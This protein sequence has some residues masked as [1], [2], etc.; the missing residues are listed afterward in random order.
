MARPGPVRPRALG[1]G[2]G[3]REAGRF[4]VKIRLQVV[5][6]FAMDSENRWNDCVSS[7]FNSHAC[8]QSYDSAAPTSGSREKAIYDSINDCGRDLK[9]CCATLK[10][11][12]HSSTTSAVMTARLQRRHLSGILRASVSS[13]VICAE[14][15]A[16]AS[17][18]VLGLS[19]CEAR[20]DAW[21]EVLSPRSEP[22][23]GRPPVLL[24][25][26]MPHP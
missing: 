20:H 17:F 12:C 22:G 8:L 1:S 19:F 6:M 3:N 11:T 21:V 13:E 16:G 25:K 2:L 4:S 14:S 18:A 24:P 10:A 23:G 9:H 7:F 5:E 26:K 15:S